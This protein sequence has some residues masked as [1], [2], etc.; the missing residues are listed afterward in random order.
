MRF[1]LGSRVV[2]LGQEQTISGHTFRGFMSHSESYP[3]PYLN[4]ASAVGITRQDV[5]LCVKRLDKCLK[6]LKKEGS[7]AKSSSSAPAP[8]QEDANG[9]ADG[10]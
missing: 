9:D 7:A 8:R 3:C 10:E 4:A 2:P 6:T 1:P 5:T